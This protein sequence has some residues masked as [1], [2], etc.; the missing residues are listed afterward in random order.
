M[1]SIAKDKKQVT[2]FYSSENSLGK[3][4]YAYVSSSEKS[5]LGVDISKTTVT[6]KQ[7]AEIAEGLGIKIE[8]LVGT[9][10]PDFK[11]KYG[12]DKIDLEAN[13]WFKVLENNPQLLKY[14]IAINGEN[15]LRL[16][17]SASFKKYME[18]D[19]AGIWKN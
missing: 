5:I 19:S 6:E 16:K 12:D 13:D 3:Q 7:W 15:Y 14:P 2:L 4:I 8:E 11:E 18:E 10:H 1:G 17:T 9:D